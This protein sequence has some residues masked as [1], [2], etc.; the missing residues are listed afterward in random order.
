MSVSELLRLR[1]SFLSIK[2][3]GTQILGS[4]AYGFLENIYMYSVNLCE[5][6]I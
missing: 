5:S 2:V 4:N 1:Q 3:N 6:V